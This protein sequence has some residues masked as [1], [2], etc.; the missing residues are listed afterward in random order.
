[1]N[2][3]FFPAHPLAFVRPATFVVPVE[4]GI[5]D[6]LPAGVLPDDPWDFVQ[7]QWVGFR[8][9][10]V[11]HAFEPRG[12]VLR[13]GDDRQVV[14]SKGVAASSPD[15]LSVSS[16]RS[17]TFNGDSG[18]L[19][20][21]GRRTVRQG[22]DV[23][24]YL[25]TRFFRHFKYRLFVRRVFYVL[26]DTVVVRGGVVRRESVRG[27]FTWKVTNVVRDAVHVNANHILRDSVWVVNVTSVI[28]L[29][30][31]IVG[32]RGLI[33]VLQRDGLNQVV[34]FCSGV[35]GNITHQ[36]RTNRR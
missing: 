4:G 18:V 26:A 13:M 25:P 31:N 23:H 1:M 19:F 12:A 16:S 6:G 35:F 8:R 9:L 17:G 20:R 3:H 36:G 24:P 30:G 27:Q 28:K 10:R 33:S 7:Q 22:G 2:N 14:P 32:G 5:Q 21:P 15:G 34:D 11:I 29:K